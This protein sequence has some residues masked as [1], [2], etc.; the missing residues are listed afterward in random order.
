MS[1]AANSERLGGYGG[2]RARHSA[3]ADS[4]I[5]SGGQGTARPTNLTQSQRGAVTMPIYSNS[6][7]IL[8]LR[9]PCAACVTA[10]LTSLSG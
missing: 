5:V 8:P 7:M 3:R 1:V 6:K 9:L 10:A 2:G 4:W